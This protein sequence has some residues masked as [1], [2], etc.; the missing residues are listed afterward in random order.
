M[1]D[2]SVRIRIAHP[3]RDLA[4]AETFYVQGLGL[5]FCGAPPSMCPA[6][7]TCS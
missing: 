1:I 2:A 7:T 6:S 4:A 3:S 5:K